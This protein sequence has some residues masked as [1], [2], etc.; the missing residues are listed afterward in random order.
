MRFYQ[1]KGGEQFEFDAYVFARTAERAG[2]LF[3]IQLI[4]NGESP[5]QMMWREL[6]VDDFEEPNRTRLSEALALGVEGV[7]MHEPERGWW[8]VPPYELPADRG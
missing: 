1:F 6:G 4:M 2:E 8:P 3:V 7:A 5:D